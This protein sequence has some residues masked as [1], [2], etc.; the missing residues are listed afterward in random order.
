MTRRSKVLCV[1]AITIVLL[2]THALTLSAQERHQAFSAV[3][4]KHVISGL[5]NYKD[6]CQDPRL[7]EYLDQLSRTSPGSLN[8][9]DAKAFWINAY[10][11]FTLQLICR[12][13]PLASINEL[14]TGGL[15]VGSVIGKTAWDRQFIT[16]DG[17]NY[18]L[19]QIEHKILRP[20]YKDP[21][22]HFAIVCAARSC[23]PLRSEAYEGYKLDRQLDDQ[24]MTFLVGRTDLNRFDLKERI[25]NISSIFSW[26]LKDFGAD[27]RQLLTYLADF[28]PAEISSDIRKDVSAWR[29]RFNAYDWSLN[30]Q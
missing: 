12:N 10:N 30:E 3:L 27:R 17:K 9:T 23:P 22:I 28:L 6:L 24:G 15:I 4:G 25:A 26:F 14:H 21:R 18:S 1:M 2:F 5:V 11:G 7:Q 20:V 29:I 13:Y 8:D 16:I 19:G